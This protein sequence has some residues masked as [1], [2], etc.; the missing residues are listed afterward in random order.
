MNREQL[1]MGE[2]TASNREHYSK[3]I[4]NREHGAGNREHLSKRPGT[5]NI[6]RKRAIKQGT[7]RQKQSVAGTWYSPYLL[8]S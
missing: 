7:M 3:I 1:G 8:Q 6:R 2:E 4:G 5:G